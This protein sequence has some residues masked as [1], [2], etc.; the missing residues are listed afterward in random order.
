MRTID[1][2]DDM[3][4]VNERLFVDGSHQCVAAKVGVKREK[5]RQGSEI[6]VR[7]HTGGRSNI[8]NDSG[9]RNGLG[10]VGPQHNTLSKRSVHGAHSALYW[11]SAHDSVHGMGGNAPHHPPNRHCPKHALNASTPRNAPRTR[12]MLTISWIFRRRTHSGGR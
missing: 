5:R 7:R 2:L 1:D 12:Q 11:Y 8:R 9:R 6:R 10:G 4:N 3:V